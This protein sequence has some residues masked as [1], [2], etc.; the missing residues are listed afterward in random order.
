M[1]IKNAFY[2]YGQGLGKKSNW[3]FFKKLLESTT[4]WP[5]YDTIIARKQQW[6]ALIFR[7]LLSISVKKRAT[8]L[9]FFLSVFKIFLLSWWCFSF[10]RYSLVGRG[11]YTSIFPNFPTFSSL[12]QR[13]F[14]S[15][16]LNFL[17]F[18]FFSS[19]FRYLLSISLK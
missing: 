9:F 10:F 16:F 8:I 6:T 4:K 15:F 18:S 11:L 1:C 17:I 3:V 12:F 14:L 7:N 5:N 13:H 2:F 19:F